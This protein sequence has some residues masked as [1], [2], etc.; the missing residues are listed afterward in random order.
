MRDN[1]KAFVAFAARFF[2]VPAPIVEIGSLQTSGQEGYADLR[3]LFPGKEYHGCDLMPGPGVDRIEDSE[4]L[5]FPD[6]SVGTIVA[7][8]SLEHVANPFHAVAEM[9]RVVAPGGMVIVATP[10]I[11]PIHHQPD[12]TRFTPEGMA[13][14]L[15]EFPVAVVFSQGDAQWPHTVYGLAA[16][17][18]VAA[19]PGAIHRRASELAL[20]VG[21]TRAHEPPL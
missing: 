13:H 21:G 3:A 5:S 19:D 15:S 6:A 18:D 14:L 16:K 17:A 10:F 2:D 12:F 8:D 1:V 11:F 9:H 4:H 20:E 7:A